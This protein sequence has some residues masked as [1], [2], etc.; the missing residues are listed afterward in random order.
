MSTRVFLPFDKVSEKKQK[1]FYKNRVKKNS[2]SANTKHQ[3][4]EVSTGCQRALA[5]CGDYKIHC[6]C[7]VP[8][9]SCNGHGNQ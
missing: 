9:L 7:N 2:I 8:T 4:S 3:T 5:L 6:S 1:N